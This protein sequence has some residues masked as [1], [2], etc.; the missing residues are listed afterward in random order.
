M[1]ALSPD[2]TGRHPVVVLVIAKCG[3]GGDLELASRLRSL[4]GQRDD[5]VGLVEVP[6]QL[7]APPPCRKLSAPNGSA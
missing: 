5:E 7:V 4:D 3:S 2:R 1:P 6:L